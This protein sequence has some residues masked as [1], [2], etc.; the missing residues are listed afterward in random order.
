MTE[1]RKLM[2]D[3]VEQKNKRHDPSLPEIHGDPWRP[4]KQWP[5][6]SPENIDKGPTVPKLKKSP[7]TGL[8]FEQGNKENSSIRG[9]KQPI[10][11]LPE[12]H[13]D[14]LEPENT[15]PIPN[16]KKHHEHPPDDIPIGLD[17]IETTE[18]ESTSPAS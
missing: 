6:K 10:K 3:L 15:E 16:E 9:K 5:Y 12:I 14:P 2:K 18:P 13:G 4:E 17:E 11:A 1:M 8:H 7:L